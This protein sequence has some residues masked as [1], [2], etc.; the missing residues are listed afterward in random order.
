[1]SAKKEVDIEDQIKQIQAQRIKS[2]DANESKVAFGTSSAGY[3]QELYGETAETYNTEIIDEPEEETVKRS[4]YSGPKD[5]YDDLVDDKVDPFAQ[6]RG[7]NIRE[8]ESDY[9]A[10]RHAHAQLSPQRS[11]PFASNA[12]KS[13][14]SYVEIMKNNDLEKEEREVL[15]K[16]KGKEPVE[17]PRRSR[18]DVKAPEAKP[19]KSEWDETESEN[20]VPVKKSRWDQT[21]V[22]MGESSGSDTPVIKKSR[23]DE[24]PLVGSG[25]G[26]E[27]PRRSKSRW[28]ETPVSES[29]MGSATPLAGATPMMTPIHQMTAEQW[30]TYKVEKEMDE[31]NRP[32]SDEELDALIP[33]KGYAVLVPPATYQPIRTPARK[34]AATPTPYLSG[35]SMNEPL[36]AVTSGVQG[37]EMPKPQDESLPFV[38]PEDYQHFSKLLDNKNDDDLTIEEIKERK[39]MRLLLK[40]KNGTPQMRKSALKQ[41]TERARDLGAGP[42]LNQIL[43]LLMTPTLED[44]ERHLLVKVIDRILYKLDDLVRPYVHKILVVIEPLLIDEDYYARIEGREIISNLS[45]AAG[46]STMIAAMRPDIDHVDEYVR[47]TTAR[48]FSVVTSALGIQ[49]VLPF[50]KA[51]CNSKKSWQARHTGIKIV[52]QIAILMGCAVLPHLRSL[53]EAIGHGLTDEQQKVR[54]ITALSLASLAEAASP[55]GIESFDTVLKPLWKGIRQ[56]RGKVLASFLKAIG[57]IIPLM[58]AEYASYYTKEVMVILIREFQTPDEEMKKIVLKVV[59]QCVSTEGVTPQYIKQEILPDYFK[60]FW[61]RRMALDR[62]NYRQVIET[63]VEIANKVGTK[64]IMD[65]VV[66]DLKDESET[67]RKMVIETLDKIVQNLGVADVDPRLEELLMDGL[68]YAFQEQTTDDLTLLNG[69]GTIVNALGQRT[70]PYLN[71]ICST[72]LWRLNNKSAKVRQQAADLVSRIAAV[73]MKCGEEKLLAHLGVVLYEC[74]GEEYPEVLGSIL[75]ALR[76]I[77]AVI[78]MNDMN[79]PIKDLLPRLTPILRNRHEKVQENVI[80]LIG[81]IADRSAESVSAREWMRI[82]FELIEVLK[83]H[84][85]SIRRAAINTFGYIA[86][87]IGPQDVLSTLLSNLKVQERQL[88]ICTTIAIA[89][90]AESCAPFTVLPA[91]MNEY[92]VPDSN[93]QNGVLK[94]MQFLFEYIGEM[95]KDYIYAVAPLFEDALIDRDLIHRQISCSAVKH[96]AIDAFGAGMEDVLAHLLNLVWPN[97]FE[98][99]PHM[100]TAVIDAIDGLRVGLGGGVILFFLLQGLFHPA[101]RVRE[102]YWRLYNNLYM[103]GAHQL[104]PFYPR[105]DNDENNLYNRFELDLFI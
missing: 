68:L 57:F 39:I 37:M 102:V 7:K 29:G 12:Q 66:S 51:V 1:M 19:K 62:R 26:S 47:N 58:D 98:T 80:D 55:Y 40:I 31:R 85:K 38:K 60:Y 81:R 4:S 42:L 20:E 5:L 54:T 44:Q 100:I 105:I 103:N 95:A 56:H 67:F 15:R 18:W 8:R 97:I 70:K 16:I 73:M 27:T 59:K 76:A 65:R 61:I 63:T 17:E 86:K 64:E 34:L 52:Q 30:N 69:F 14:K 48:A 96:L 21:P 82:C 83:A 33:K 72:V 22:S 41:I 84:R 77:V 99:S 32:L 11:D 88:R 74:L 104:V 78:G 23:W 94:T 92:R 89:I 9:H 93:V 25:V 87:A 36:T 6:T 46:L 50:I 45:K 3:D 79:P 101:R 91:L 13:E 71:Q 53:V 10:R 24:T 35:F 43:P 49:T 90:I 2:K 28:D 75:G